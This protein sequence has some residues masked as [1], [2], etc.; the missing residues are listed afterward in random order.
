VE[1]AGTAGPPPV[2]I[3]WTGCDVVVLES[4]PRAAQGD[5]ADLVRAVADRGTGLL[6]A[7]GRRLLNEDRQAAEQLAAVSPARL[8]RDEFGIAGP[9]QFVPT[10]AGVAHPVL[11][12]LGALDRTQAATQPDD[13]AAWLRL[14]PLGGAARV[15]DPKPAAEVLARDGAGRP[16][17]IAQDVGRGR[18]IL[19]A[20]ESTWPWALSSDEGAA[21]HRGLWQQML[22]WL[23]NRRPQAWLITD[24]PT[25]PLQAVVGGRRKIQVRAGVSAPR[26]SGSKRFTEPR[27]VIVTPEGKHPVRLEGRGDEWHADLPADIRDRPITQAGEYALEFSISASPGGREDLQRLEARTSFALVEAQLELQPPTANLALLRSAAELAAAQ[28][29]GFWSIEQLADVLK[30]LAEAERGEEVRTRVRHAVAERRPGTLLAL[31]VAALGLEWAVRKRA[32][33]S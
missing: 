7:G 23:A 8:I 19:A 18:S 1:A 17:L 28:G 30:K 20:W 10:L 9:L 32:G 29:G 33:L 2:P 5:L 27:L 16:L 12:G 14:P 3:D 31:L 15:G 22:D 11:Q 25:Y 6:L 24:E 4:A 26:N 21:L 13:R